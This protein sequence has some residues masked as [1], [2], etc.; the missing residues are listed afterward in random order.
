MSACF[1]PNKIDEN[2]NKLN[3]FRTNIDNKICNIASF[4]HQICENEVFYLKCLRE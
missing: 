2:G 3:R 1:R 4:F